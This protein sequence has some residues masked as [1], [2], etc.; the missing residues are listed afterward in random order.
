MSDAELNYNYN[1]NYNLDS[2]NK[3]LLKSIYLYTYN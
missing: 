3:Y 2:V 1:Y